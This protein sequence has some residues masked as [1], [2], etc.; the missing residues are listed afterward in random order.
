MHSFTH[1]RNYN[2]GFGYRR[3]LFSKLAR[4]KLKD[5]RIFFRGYA[6][7]RPI[8]R[9]GEFFKFLMYCLYAFGVSGAMTAALM[10]LNDADLRSLPGFVTPGIPD[11][12]CF[13]EGTL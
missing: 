8:H 9:R 7:A 12:G 10:V 1:Q 3:A 5:F 4:K 13:L 2:A 11:K 6:K